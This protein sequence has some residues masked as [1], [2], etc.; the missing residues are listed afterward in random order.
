MSVQKNGFGN[1]VIHA[2]A[3]ADINGI[4][5]YEGGHFDDSNGGI[6]RD[7]P[8][9]C[10][11]QVH[12]VALDTFLEDEPRVDLIKMDIEGA[13]GLALKG[14]IKLLKRHRPILFTEFSPNA[15]RGTS[16]TSPED[17]LKE[18][19]RLGYEL[20][21]LHK[22]RGQNRLPQS[23][24]EIMQCYAECKSDHLDLVAIPRGMRDRC[25]D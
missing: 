17:Y 9:A 14:M 19:R 5:G 16:G 21:V 7:N 22:G 15:L 18:L 1:V 25:P 11:T 20:Y 8:T 4:V 10:L 13:E 6:N 3:V 12:A 23:D 2:K 24:Q